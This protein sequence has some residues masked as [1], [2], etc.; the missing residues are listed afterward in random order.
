[1]NKVID[2]INLC[3]DEGVINL[4]ED[5]GEDFSSDV[6]SDSEDFLVPGS[7]IPTREDLL[8]PGS[9]IP[10]CDHPLSHLRHVEGCILCQL[11]GF[12]LWNRNN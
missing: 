11:C 5:D 6:Q 12:I 4:C 8:D 10:T 3:E 2:I 7:S 9:S 1:M